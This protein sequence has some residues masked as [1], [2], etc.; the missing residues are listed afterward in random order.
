MLLY[1]AAGLGV[2][3]LAYQLVL[4][5]FEVAR[6][7]TF[8]I[9][10]FTLG[11]GLIGIAIGVMNYSRQKKKNISPKKIALD[12]LTELYQVRYKFKSKISIDFMGVKETKISLRING[13]TIEKMIRY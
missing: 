2:L 13:E 11:I 7:H 8:T 12:Y 5:L 4:S 1:G 10:V 3:F 6:I 9:V